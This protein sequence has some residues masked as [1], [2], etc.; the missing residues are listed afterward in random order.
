MSTIERSVLSR[1][2]FGS[3]AGVAKWASSGRQQAPRP[4]SSTWGPLVGAPVCLQ[5]TA[6]VFTDTVCLERDTANMGRTSDVG[7]PA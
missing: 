7:E 6:D 2:A 1:S 5:N 4:W 3:S